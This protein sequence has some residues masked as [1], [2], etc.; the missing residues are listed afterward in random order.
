MADNKA[1]TLHPPQS[2]NPQPI[3]GTLPVKATA[4]RAIAEMT[5]G[6][7]KV[8][9]ELGN[10]SQITFL[11]SCGLSAMHEQILQI[12]ARAIREIL[13]VLGQ[14]EAVNAD[15]YERLC[16]QRGIKRPQSPLAGQSTA[17]ETGIPD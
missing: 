12:R 10:L 16:T 11:R 15:Y 9:H 1:N 4:Y 3:A 5:A 13:S 14:R 8:I 6:F 2:L 7:E 17:P